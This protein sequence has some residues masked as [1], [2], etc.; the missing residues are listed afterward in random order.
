LVAQVTARL[1]ATLDVDTVLQTAVREM[2]SA[3]GIEK[4]ELRLEPPGLR[5]SPEPL[6]GA[7]A[8][9]PREEDGHAGLD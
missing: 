1:R 7:Q 6:Q 3:L 5:D 8:R 4:V 2:G 9:T